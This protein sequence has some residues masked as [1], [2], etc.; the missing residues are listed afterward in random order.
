VSAAIAF[1][2]ERH[3]YTLA[4]RPVPSVTQVLGDVGLED[5]S[6]VPAEALEFARVR[7]QHCH[8]AMALIARDLLDWSSLDAELLPYVESGARF[9][10]ESGLTIIA[11]ELIVG[12]AMHRVAGTLDLIAYW[13]GAESV[14]DYKFTATFPRS[15]GPQTAGYSALYRETFRT[16]P[17]KKRFAVLLSPIGY[18]VHPLTD[19]R[20]ETVFFSALNVYHWKHPHAA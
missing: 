9:L 19:R 20:D 1:D 12:S 16:P 6:G 8:E 10:R 14:I 15:V 5:F 4:G 7:G 17:P 18:R 3:A 11:S 2:A 13:R